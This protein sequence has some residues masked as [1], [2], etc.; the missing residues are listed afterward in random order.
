MSAGAIASDEPSVGLVSATAQRWTLAG[1]L[2]AVL[3]NLHHAAPWVLPV[4]LAGI[5]WRLWAAQHPSRLMGRG[6]RLS[7]V[8]VLTLAVLVSFRTLNGVA[9]GA[10]LLVAMA[11]L[12]LMETRRLRDWRIIIGASVFL[13][14]AACLDA[15]ALWRMPLYATEVWLLCAALYA[16]GAAHN[17]PAAATLLRTAGRSLL[18]ALPLALLLFLFFPRMTGTLWAVPRED[19]AVTGLGEQMSPGSISDLIESD[20]AAM[21]VRF[22]GPL[23]PRSER[24]WRGPVLH[25][26]DGYTWRRVHANL[27]PPPPL[28]FAGRSYGYEVTLEPSKLGV[29]IALELPA[30][31][32]QQLRPVSASFDY[33]LLDPE[34][35]G[36][37]T[38]YR[39]ESFPQHRSGAALSETV[40]ELDLA[41]PAHRN[42]RSLALAHSLRASAR[43]A[44]AY[45]QSV[46]DYLQRGG[47]EYTRRPPRL[48]LNSVDDLLFDTHEGFCGH[49][50]SAFATLMRAGG[51][52][53]RVV[54]GY[55]GGEWNR[56]GA[57]LLVRQANA[58]AW[59]EVWLDGSGWVRVDPTAVVAPERLDRE[60][61]DAL[62]G[63]G[64]GHDRLRVARWVANTVQAWQA[65]NAWWQDE[66]IGF[67]IVKQL[68]LLGSLGLKDRDL[69]ALVAVVA[70]GGTLWLALLSWRARRSG[71]VRRDALGRSWHGLERALRRHAAGRALHEGPVAYGERIAA[72]HPELAG[73][74]RPLARQY[75][76]LRYGRDGS[77]AQRQRFSR[78]VRLF[79]ARLRC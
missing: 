63:A 67:N 17:V 74:L 48:S 39:L 61:D 54:T 75:A 12:K 4:A 72:E 41:L 78:A 10:S 6:A 29:L 59:T 71:R 36:D 77:E 73:T 46:L 62:L 69:Q 57:Y 45:V 25:E 66:F 20:E 8:A 56:F 19:Q 43:D 53:A 15:P 47:F 2:G 11:A 50:A 58:H 5:A 24:Y 35:K 32:P 22:D 31:V 64:T 33:Q 3:L 38:S 49:Y 60:L 34:S 68:N 70:A 14:L 76:R 21:R 13:V 42:P 65:M 37:A 1:L 7:I 40:R 9:A 18:L 23:P 27:G 55:L 30:G 44:R 52:P 16:L 28:E 26:F 51:V 79:T